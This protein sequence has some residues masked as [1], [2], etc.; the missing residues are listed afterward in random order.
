M[1]AMQDTP[2]VPDDAHE[3]T[4]WAPRY[5]AVLLGMLTLVSAGAFE[6][7]AVATAMPVVVDALGGLELYA[8]AFAAP[9]AGGVLGMVV[10][11]SLTDRRGPAPATLVGAALFAL[12]LVVAGTAP[13]MGVVVAGRG[14]QGVGTGMFSV[15][16][17]VVVARTFPERLQAR[18]LAAFAAAW[19]VPAI[20]GPALAGVVA[21]TLG[22]R[23][24]FLA[25]P[26]LCV[27]AVV[28]LRPALRGLGRPGAPADGAPRGL[29][30][31]GL[32]AALGALALHVGGQRLEAGVAPGPA[33]V[34]VVGLTLLGVAA[35]RL[36]PRG[37]WRAARGLPTVVLVR[38]LL[39]CA[40]FG[41]EVY[42]PLLLQGERGM[43][44]AH[45]GLALTFAALT[46]SLGSWLRGRRPEGR[47]AQLLVAGGVLIAAGIGAAALAVAPG[48]P[49]AVTV[50]GWSAGGLGM[51][52]TYP[53]ASLLTLR[54]AAP[55][56]Q[57]RSTSALQVAEAL[58]VATLLAL[59][60]PLFVELRAGGATPA[61]LTVLA[62]AALPAA[63]AA[64]VARRVVPSDPAVP[65]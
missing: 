29:V 57:G 47:D 50:L 30:P 19:V 25:V 16:L 41:A 63:A 36:L 43:H 28:A 1:T 9:V 26:V 45:A 34:V 51:G 4:P 33:A 31:T 58:A 40:F 17:Y 56:E 39:A 12:G 8:T 62:L 18:V 59:L 22:W 38:G 6:G 53:T 10:S 35:P 23:W 52:L 44:P 37:T 61:Y 7:M 11:G 60:G 5:R 13:S 49:V 32:A 55:G 3:R 21:T 65:R 42:V 54:L 27:V 48:V 14:V 20:V 64:A 2:A 46:W 15:A 24:V